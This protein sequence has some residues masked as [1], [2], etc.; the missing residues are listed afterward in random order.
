MKV[1]QCCVLLLLS[2]L[3]YGQ[4]HEL[5]LNLM[6]LEHHTI[7]NSLDWTPKFLW[8]AYYSHQIGEI[9][10]FNS[11]EY[12]EN[13]I[14]TT[15]EGCTNPAIAESR[16]IEFNL[17]SGLELRKRY[18]H[19]SFGTRASIYFSRLDYRGI[20]EAEYYITIWYPPVPFGA[21]YNVLASQLEFVL[22]ANLASGLT[23]NVDFGARMGKAWRKSNVV[24]SSKYSDEVIF[25]ITFPI[26]RLGYAF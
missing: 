10:L 13:L 11:F 14:K 22:S 23:L 25:A 3:T 16:Y 12:G 17:T 15:C 18:S 6:K 8:G 7:T 24:G 21:K 9:R 19:F 2:H 4:K 5:G 26:I 20:E 1:F